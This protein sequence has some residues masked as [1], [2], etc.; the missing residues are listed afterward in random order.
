MRLA[1]GKEIILKKEKKEL[2]SEKIEKYYNSFELDEDYAKN[3][4]KI[5]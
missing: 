1:T 2:I 5:F 4:L 3:Y